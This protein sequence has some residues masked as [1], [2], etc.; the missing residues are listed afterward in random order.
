MTMIG[1]GRHYSRNRSIEL[2]TSQYVRYVKNYGHH[3]DTQPVER[4]CF[5]ATLDWLSP[6]HP[7]IFTPQLN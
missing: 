5:I 4:N 7:N 3:D 6:G 2:R 1:K